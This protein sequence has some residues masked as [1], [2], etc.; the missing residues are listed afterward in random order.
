ML[1]RDNDGGIE[2]TDVVIVGAAPAGL[3]A[4]LVLGRMRRTVLVVD[5]DVPAHAVSDGVHGFLA[6][7][8]SP[9]MP[10]R[11]IGRD[12]LK[13]YASV[14]TSPLAALL[15]RTSEGGASDVNLQG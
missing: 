2:I 11:A 1:K 10:L 9:R 8:G 14:E 4:A 13:P 15:A 5:T 12:Y 3:S 6:Q 7:K